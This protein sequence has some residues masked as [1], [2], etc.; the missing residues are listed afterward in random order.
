[1]NIIFNI[2]L[3]I[4]GITWFQERQKSETRKSILV[5]TLAFIGANILIFF[6]SMAI[7]QDYLDGFLYVIAG[8]ANLLIFWIWMVVSIIRHNIKRKITHQTPS[9]LAESSIVLILLVLLF[10]LL[11]NTPTKIGG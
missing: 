9:D 3:L 2:I 7:Q 11:V 4:L 10:F 6:I 1:M 5:V 8:A